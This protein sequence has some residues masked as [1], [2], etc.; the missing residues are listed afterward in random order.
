LHPRDEA[1][2]YRDLF[3]QHVRSGAI[4]PIQGEIVNLE[5]VRIQVEIV[6][7]VVALGSGRKIIQGIF[8]RSSPH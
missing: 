7:E 1:V 8:R 6:G 4:E 2:R 3:E 5:G